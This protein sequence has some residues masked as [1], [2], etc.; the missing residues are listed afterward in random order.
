[1][2]SRNI[3]AK[4]ALSAAFLDQ[5]GPVAPADEVPLDRLTDRET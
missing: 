5:P 2:A 3:T 4:N 1:V